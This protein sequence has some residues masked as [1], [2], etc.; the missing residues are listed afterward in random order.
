MLNFPLQDR[1]RLE[2]NRVAIAFFLQ[3]TVQGWIGKGRIAAKELW[4]IQVAIPLDHRQQ[5]SPPELGT[6]VIAAP[7]HR[8][9]QVAELVE[10]E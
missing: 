4:D 2:A 10:Q 7:E 1:V 5:H 8:S 9:F 3:Q 6:G